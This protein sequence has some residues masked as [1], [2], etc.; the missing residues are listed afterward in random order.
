MSEESVATHDGKR[1]VYTLYERGSVLER[2]NVGAWWT[3]KKGFIALGFPL[4]CAVEASGN[5]FGKP[6]RPLG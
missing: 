4:W 2:G 3:G 6:A 1:M 5:F